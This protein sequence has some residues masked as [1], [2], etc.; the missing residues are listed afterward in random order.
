[1]SR[2]DLTSDLIRLKRYCEPSSGKGSASEAV[3]DMF[4]DKNKRIISA[5]RI[6]KL[7]ILWHIHPCNVSHPLLVPNIYHQSFLLSRG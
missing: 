7:D 2:A 1:M 4:K 5:L 3:L 6:A